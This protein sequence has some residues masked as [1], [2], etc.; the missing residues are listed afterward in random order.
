ME[1]HDTRVHLLTILTNQCKHRAWSWCTSS[2][3]HPPSRR[4]LPSFRSPGPG[5]VPS[6]DDAGTSAA[7]RASTPDV[8]QRLP[9]SPFQAS[10]LQMSASSH[11]S[12]IRSVP[13]LESYENLSFLKVPL[14]KRVVFGLPCKTPGK[15]YDH[16]KT[17]LILIGPVGPSP[18]CWS[19]P[20]QRSRK[21]QE[22]R[23][24]HLNRWM[25][26]K[27][28]STCVTQAGAWKVYLP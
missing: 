24:G 12:D 20:F 22:K 11:T 19:M 15:G 28:Y 1:P 17:I 27:Q 23:E 4:P 8:S 3:S 25:P 9:T 21:A 16:K 10:K 18:V 6:R 7:P 26:L 5:A 13:P 2:L 14:S